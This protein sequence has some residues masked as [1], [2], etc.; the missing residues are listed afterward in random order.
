[1]WSDVVELRDFYRTSLGRMTRRILRQRIRSLWPQVTGMSVLGIGYATPFLLPFQDEA[2]RVTAVMPA[3]Q[4]VLRW[5]REGGCLVALA[6]EAELPFPDVSFDRVILVHAL[7][8]SEQVRP[9]LREVWRVLADGG[10]VLLV[11]PNRRGVWA[12]RDRTPFGAGQPYTPSQLSRLLRDNLFTPIATST[13]L[14]APPSRSRMMIASAPAW[15]KVGAQ[16]FESF[17]GVLVVEAAKQI[18]AA[19]PGSLVPARR[20]RP[21]VA[22]P[23]PVENMPA[24]QTREITR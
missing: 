12:R 2:V 13:A 4:G 10:R 21:Y 16:L 8:C 18:Y 17:G 5:P 1:M 3:P 7:E 11:V 14:F 15:E 23:G 6:D 19:T 20:R 9:M 22:V 24:R